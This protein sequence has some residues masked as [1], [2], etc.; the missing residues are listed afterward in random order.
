MAKNQVRFDGI[1]EFKKVLS[2]VGK[3]I[4]GRG[5]IN[6]LFKAADPIVKSSRDIAAQDARGT[7]DDGF[8]KLLFLSKL[9]QKRRYK[10]GVTISLNKRDDVPVKGLIGRDAFTAFGWAR[11]MAQGR[12]W[13]ART[14]S[15]RRRYWT[16][17][18][19]G[20]GDFIDKGF[21]ASWRQS[22]SIYKKIRIPEIMRVYKNAVNRHMRN[23]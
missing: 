20:K 23:L 11:L 1:N 17:K 21:E 14:S 6:A 13:T 8:S 12:Q 5:Q 18:T 2:D 16:G 15:S 7:D 4:E 3:D 22:S 10:G 19:E 9:I